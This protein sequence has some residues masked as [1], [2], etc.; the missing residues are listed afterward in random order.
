MHCSS[1]ACLSQLTLSSCPPQFQR[2][3]WE[4]PLFSGM[5]GARPCPDLPVQFSCTHHNLSLGLLPQVMSVSCGHLLPWLY[6]PGQM[7]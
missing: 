1:W 6:L 7:S 4:T 3:L 2:S 5:F